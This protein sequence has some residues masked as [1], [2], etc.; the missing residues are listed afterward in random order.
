MFKHIYGLLNGQELGELR[1]IAAAA[2]FVDGKISNPHSQVKHNLHLNDEDAYK[3]SSAIMAGALMR[4]EEFR[5]FAIPKKIAPPLI[6]RYEPEMRYGLHPDMA[7][8]RTHEGPIR[9]DLSC[10]IFLQDPASYEGGELHIKLGD[11]NLRFKGELGSAI[12]YPST[13]LHEVEKVT[14]GERLVGITFIE[15]QVV[16]PAKRELIYELNEVAAIEGAN[17]STESYTRLQ[18]VQQ[19]LFRRWGDC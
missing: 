18:T 13:T 6:T 9:S 7:F 2:T 19:N 14:R 5:G 12:V 3:R 8:M 15:S 16:D 11:G 1:E 17:I 4:N 10:T